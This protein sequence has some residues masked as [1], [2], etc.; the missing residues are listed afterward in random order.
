MDKASDSALIEV[1]ATTSSLP[2]AN[3]RFENV[4]RAKYKH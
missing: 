3:A 1:R 4:G 2:K